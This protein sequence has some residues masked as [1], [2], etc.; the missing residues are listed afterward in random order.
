MQEQFQG[1]VQSSRIACAGGGDRNQIAHVIPEGAGA[2]LGLPGPHPIDVAPNGID[3]PV[4]AQVAKGL[5]QVPGGKGVG[6]VT[7]VDQ[8][9]GAGHG[10]IRQV[11]VKCGHLIRQQHTLVYQRP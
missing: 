9:Q 3:L 10:R 11:R 4:V 7:L 2:E 8:R 6:A 5:G 1:V